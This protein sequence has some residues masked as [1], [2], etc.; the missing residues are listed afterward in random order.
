MTTIVRNPAG[1]GPKQRPA[2]R[3]SRMDVWFAVFNLHVNNAGDR[4]DAEFI[5]NFG[6]RRFDRHIAPAHA[7]GIMSIFDGKLNKWQLVWVAMVAAFVNE[8][9]RP[10]YAEFEVRP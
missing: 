3:D 9:R 5:A 1:L 7:A 10:F 2:D 6:Q 8:Q 4:A